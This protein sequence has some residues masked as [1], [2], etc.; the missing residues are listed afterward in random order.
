MIKIYII[1]VVGKIASGKTMVA[2]LLQ[3]LLKD[4][5][6]LNVDSLAKEIY[7]LKK[8]VIYKLKD[9]FGSCVFNSKNKLNFNKLGEIVFS[10]KSNLEKLNKIML[11]EID[12]IIINFINKAHKEGNIKFLIID[13]AIL[14]SLT[15]YKY[16]NYIIY[17]KSDIKKRIKR[18]MAKNNISEHEAVLRIKGQYIKLKRKLINYQINNTRD[19]KYLESEI[20]NITKEILNKNAA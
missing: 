1:G 13:A 19:L 9:C 4:S 14:F 15:A 3:N 2:N 12:K 16:C 20:Y 6:I 17:V 10:S 18:L 11:P 7:N 5:Y 8:D